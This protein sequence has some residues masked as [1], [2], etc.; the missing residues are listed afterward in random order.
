MSVVPVSQS[1]WPM[2]AA[3]IAYGTKLGLDMIGSLLNSAASAAS[4]ASAVKRAVVGKRTKVKKTKVR[5]ARPKPTRAPVNVPVLAPLAEGRVMTSASSSN[6]HRERASYRLANVSGVALEDGRCVLTMSVAPY[7][8]GARFRVMAGLYTMY[9]IRA[10]RLN[11]RPL[12][13]TTQAGGYMLVYGVDSIDAPAVAS[14]G[15][16]EEESQNRSVIS[17]PCWQEASLQCKCTG[18][19]LYTSIASNEP[20]TTLDGY[21]ALYNSSGLHNSVTGSLWVDAEIEFAVPVAMDHVPTGSVVFGTPTAPETGTV[22]YKWSLDRPRYITATSMWPIGSKTWTTDCF[23]IP[24]YTH[25]K[26]DLAVEGTG[27]A[28]GGNWS[29]G[30]RDA[31]IGQIYSKSVTN[32]TT[33]IHIATL[34]AYTLGDSHQ[35]MPW[36]AFTTISSARF[37][38]SILPY[39]TSAM[40][41]ESKEEAKQGVLETTLA[42][43]NNSVGGGATVAPTPAPTPHEPFTVVS[44]ARALTGH[45]VS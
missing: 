32:G 35:F 29:W 34:E 13:A 37:S 36:M 25:Y 31:N 4:S 18:R 9:R 11:Y 14:T 43:V 7:Y 40:G 10:L 26:A 22:L 20:H 45:F 16:L 39:A 6:I 1:S 28:A 19:W 30:A 12:V 27:L 44:K 21:I 41:S 42:H 5:S 23:L 8:L 38:I 33:T 17:F 15:S 24:P 2:K 3:K